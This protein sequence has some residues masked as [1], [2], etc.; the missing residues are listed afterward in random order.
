MTIL[1]IKVNALGNGNGAT[2]L[3]FSSLQEKKAYVKANLK[4]EKPVKSDGLDL[5]RTVVE[6]QSFIVDLEAWAESE[7]FADPIGF[8]LDLEA[9]AA[10][11]EVINDFSFKVWEQVLRFLAVCSSNVKRVRRLSELLSIEEWTAKV[12]TSKTMKRLGLKG[13][14]KL[15]KVLVGMGVPMKKVELLLGG[16]IKQSNKVSNKLSYVTNVEEDILDQG[17]SVYYTSCQATDTRAKWFGGNEYNKVHEDVILENE[18]F[19]W[20]IGQPMRVDGKGFIARAKLRLLYSDEQVGGLYIDRP[21]GAH[22]MLLDNICDLHEWWNTKCKEEGWKALP[23]YIAPTWNR[24]EGAGNDFESSYGGV[25]EELYCPSADFGYQ[26]TM[27]RGEGPYSFF[28]T[29]DSQEASMTKSAYV[30]RPKQGSVYL[31]PLKDVHYNSQ[32]GELVYPSVKNQPWRGV[33]SSEARELATFMV[34]VFGAPSTRFNYTSGCTVKVINTWEGLRLI[35]YNDHYGDAVISYDHRNM[36]CYNRDNSSLTVVTSKCELGLATP[37]QL[38]YECKDGGLL[39]NQPYEECGFA[40]ASD[41]TPVIEIIA[42]VF[43]VVKNMQEYGFAIATPIPVFEVTSGLNVIFNKVRDKAFHSCNGSSHYI[44][45]YSESSYREAI[46]LPY[47]Y[48]GNTL[49]VTRNLASEFGF[50]V[51]VS[52]TGSPLHRIMGV[53]TVMSNCEFSNYKKAVPLTDGPLYSKNGTTEVRNGF[54]LWG[55]IPALS[56]DMDRPFYVQRDYGQ[57]VTEKWLELFVC[58]DLKEMGYMKAVKLSDKP[59][60]SVYV[61]IEHKLMDWIDVEDYLLDGRTSNRYS[62]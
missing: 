21:Y 47:E 23:I 29:L 3:K 35:A 42:G 2:T 10:S 18:L 45:D 15:S 25:S 49:T 17:N 1:N 22:Q 62:D 4:A 61:P 30:N 28:H 26:D 59:K 7:G 24:E 50:A 38:P 44:P 11:N 37:I 46:S 16:S 8:E 32:K 41:Y 5:L 34:G 31:C 12:L 51:A 56:I 6:E 57:T 60:V 13:S 39:V 53:C 40:V 33:I 27:T 19:L 20:V 43:T 54:Q 48:V 14:P 36:I 9:W 58:K 52:I 55:F